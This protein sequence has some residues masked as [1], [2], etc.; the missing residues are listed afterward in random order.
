MIDIVSYR[1]RIGA[2]ATS[3]KRVKSV[4][5]SVDRRFNTGN[6]YIHTDNCY[7]PILL[8][9]CIIYSLC[10]LFLFYGISTRSCPSSYPE[11]FILNRVDIKNMIPYYVNIYMTWFTMYFRSRRFKQRCGSLV[12]MIT[13]SSG[14][15]GR[16]GKALSASI[17]WIYIL[18]M[19]LIVISN[20]SIKNP[21]PGSNLSVCF[22]NVQGL[23]PFGDLGKKHPKLDNTKCLQLTTFLHKTKTDIILL[24]ETWLKGSIRD[25]ELLPTDHFKLF[26][27]DR[28][29]QSHP[30]D[31]LNPKK[32]K[33]NGGGVAIAVR[34]D[35]DIKSKQLKL[36]CVAEILAVEFTTA[37]GQKLIIC[38]CYRVGTLGPDNHDRIVGAIRSLT[39]TKKLTKIVLVGD[40]NLPGVDWSSLASPVPIEQ[41]FVDSFVDLGLEQCVDQPTHVGGNT[42]DILLS[43]S[44]SNVL[45]L[46]V[47]ELDSVV[48]GS[49]HNPLFF[50]IS[51]RVPKRKQVKRECFKFSKAYWDGLN[52]DFCHTNWNALFS[53]GD[54]DTCS[55]ILDARI[56]ELQDKHIP[57]TTIKCDFNQGRWFDAECHQAYKKKERLRRKFRRTG[58]LTD[59]IKASAAKK[60]FKKLHDCKQ[61]EFLLGDDDGD[62]ALIKK[63]FW[64][65]NKSKTGSSRI[66]EFVTLEDESRS[67]PQD[68]AKLFNQFFCD[69]FSDRSSYDIP[70]DFSADSTF[71]IDFDHRKIRKLLMNINPSRAHGPDGV[72]GRVLKN[73]AVG[74]AYPLSLLFSMSYNT[75]KLPDKWKQAHVVPIFKSGDKHDVSNYRPISLTSLIMKT[76]E[77][78]IKD[79]ILQRVEHLLDPRQHGFLAKKSCSTN[80]IGICDSLALTLNENVSVM[81]C[82]LILQKH[83][84]Q[85]TMTLYCISSN[86]SLVLMVDC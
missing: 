17:I 44:A 1:L 27:R 30:P 81:S 54:P 50:D 80:M 43:N 32:F 6:T 72:H 56:R 79:E 3:R 24:N 73:C 82:T 70:V 23:I 8:P 64:N 74:L 65:Y 86:I 20:P 7:L 11:Q 84:I 38:T 78:V 35:L 75:G 22:H 19:V 46:R 47:A 25:S 68:Q 67:C 62:T 18:G 63:K 51:M 2:Y 10:L 49:P 39:R 83:L 77:R 33:A 52:Y 21:G 60:D 48:E 31:P 5:P 28:S 85:S 12:S 69:Q 58:D 59:G 15:R 14:F 61:E 29:V 13:K 42:L 71:D 26:R 36:G 66:P 34:T 55:G 45:N 40:F 57:K 9:L 37:S 76:F 53:S 41:K 16:A 4:R